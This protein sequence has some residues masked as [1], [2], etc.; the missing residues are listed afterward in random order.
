MRDAPP[1]TCRRGWTRD[2]EHHADRSRWR[3]AP[4]LRDRRDGARRRLRMTVGWAFVG[5]GRHPELW[6]GPALAAAA[7]ARTVGVWSRDAARAGAFAARHG[8]PRVYAT[9][10]EAL[11]DPAVDSVYISTPNSLHAAHAVAAARAGKHVLVEK[12]MATTVADATAMVRAA[13]AAG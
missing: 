7:N 12:P 1:R 6:T 5:A 10:E 13:D 8:I 9:L 2:G 11:A 3:P 4:G